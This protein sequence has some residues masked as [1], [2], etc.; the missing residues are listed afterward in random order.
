MITQILFIIQS[1]SFPWPYSFSVSLSLLLSS[2]ILFDLFFHL[3][4]ICTLALKSISSSWILVKREQI[5][6]WVESEIIFLNCPEV[7]ESLIFPFNMKNPLL[8]AA[9]WNLMPAI[10]RQHQLHMLSLACDAFHQSFLPFFS[11]LKIYFR[12]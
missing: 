10:C 9:T 3:Y 4:V 12:F 6:S 7:T 2:S 8:F 5:T 1:L 11:N